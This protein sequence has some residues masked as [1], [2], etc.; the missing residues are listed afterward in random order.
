MALFKRKTAGK[1]GEWYYCLHH[2]K[3]EEG[4]ECP[5]KDR[6]G[7]YGTQAEAARAMETAQERNAEW[8]NDPRWHDSSSRGEGGGTSG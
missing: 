1:A 5:A 3:V 6:F 7:P 2:D 4:P 8:E